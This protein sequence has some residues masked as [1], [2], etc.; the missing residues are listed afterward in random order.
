MENFCESE[1]ELPTSEE[2]FSEIS[3]N[4]ESGLVETEN[5]LNLTQVELTDFLTRLADPM[6]DS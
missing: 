5:L 3:R 4:V 2:E 6:N 1:Y